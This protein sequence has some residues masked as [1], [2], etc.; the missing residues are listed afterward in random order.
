MVFLAAAEA[1]TGVFVLLT[2]WVG[3]SSVVL[4]SLVWKSTSVYYNLENFY[5]EEK[6][7]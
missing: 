5:L 7:C 6:N 4:C 1:V 2:P 3:E